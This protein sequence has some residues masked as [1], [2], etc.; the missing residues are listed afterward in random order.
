LA[1]LRGEP[2]LATGADF[3]ATDLTVVRP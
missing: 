3:S 2:V 1:A